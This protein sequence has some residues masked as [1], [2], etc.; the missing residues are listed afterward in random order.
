MSLYGDTHRALHEKFGTGKIAS[1]LEEM[2]TDEVEEQHKAFI[3]TRDMFWLATVDAEGR[4][5]CQYK[6]GE[7]GFVRVVDSKTVVFPSY[8]GNGRFHSMG[9]IGATSNIGMLFLDFETPNRL[10]LQGEASVSAD[11]PLL[12]EY[13]EAELIVRVKVTDVIINCP[14]YIHKMKR[15]EQS[16]HV[17]ISGQKTPFAQWKRIDVVQE[18]LPDKDIGRAA[19]AGGTITMEEWGEE[20]MKGNG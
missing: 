6:G 11:D 3:E 15:V 14:R 2:D 16:R 19:E 10:R 1:L 4:P 12:S 5:Q 20:M 7:P 9:N 13:A 17:P 8:D 18:A